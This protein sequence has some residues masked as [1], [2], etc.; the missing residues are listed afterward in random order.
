M[1]A[2]GLVLS[3]CIWLYFNNNDLYR[4]GSKDLSYKQPYLI[5]K[6]EKSFWSA[7]L[8]GKNGV[9]PITHF[10]ASTFYYYKTRFACEVKNFDPLDFLDKSEIRKYDLYTQYGLVAVQKA[11]AHANIKFET[12]NGNRIGVTWGAANGSTHTLEE[13]LSEVCQRRWY[14]KIQS[15]FVTKNAY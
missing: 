4:P 11:I 12:L 9:G 10:D 15:L 8:S 5:L 7:L 3:K 1:I 14:T 6:Y 2:V 13:Q